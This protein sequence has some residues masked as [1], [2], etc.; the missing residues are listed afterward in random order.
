[1][2]NDGIGQG[3]ASRIPQRSGLFVPGIQARMLEKAR[4]SKADSIWVDLEDATPPDR[5]V[6]ARNLARQAIPLFTQ[7]VYV[8]VNS[9]PT[10]MTADDLDAVVSPALTG[11]V[12][13]KTSSADEI[14][15]VDHLLSLAE[16][17][18]GCPDGS[19][20][21]IA[22]IETAEGILNCREIFRSTTNRVTGAA[23]GVAQDGDTQRDLGYQWTPEG[24]ETLYIRS[25][26]LVEA[27]AADLVSIMEGPY[28]EHQDD[29][30]LIRQ[31]RIARQLGYLGKN[32]IHPRQVDLINQEFT[33]SEKE[34][35]YYSG[36]VVAMEAANARGE[37][38]TT[39]EGKLID[40]AHLV[41]AR[42]VLGAV[43]LRSGAASR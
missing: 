24:L 17:K 13:A 20:K 29:E 31:C 40:T 28:A 35:A 11:I 38:A 21:V 39:F 27:V 8:R 36:L 3:G 2:S 6:E 32:A 25:K 41:R 33:P 43:A 37:G 23:I 18:N 15:I 9:I 22:S 4:A 14:A 1:M 7:P 19:I 16:R 10:L 5:K 30:G 34:L 26:M 42:K 12:L